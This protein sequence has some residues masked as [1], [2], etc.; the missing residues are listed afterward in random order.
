MTLKVCKCHNDSSRITK[1]YFTAKRARENSQ[2]TNLM[3]GLHFVDGFYNYNSY[4]FALKW[5]LL[6]R[7]I[8]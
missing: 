6:D 5:S 7:L 3:H 1:Q 4:I 8:C 2:I